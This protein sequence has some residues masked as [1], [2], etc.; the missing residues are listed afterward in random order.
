MTPSNEDPG[1]TQEM[2][3]TE[4]PPL[5]SAPPPAAQGPGKGPRRRVWLAVLLGVLGGLLLGAVVVWLVLAPRGTNPPAASTVATQTPTATAVATTPQNPPSAPVE[6]P[7]Q[8]SNNAPAPPDTSPPP[9]PDPTNPAPAYWVSYPDNPNVELRWSKVHD[10]SGVSYTLQIE[11]WMGGGAGWGDPKVYSDLHQT[12]YDW[13]VM[14]D[15]KER[16]RVIAVDGAGNKSDPSVWWQ[17]IPTD[18]S[19]AASQNAKP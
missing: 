8:Q 7:G 11:E 15:L 10:P 5:G 6:Q 14:S 3:V 4:Q 18:A 9:T 1:V 17:L 13:K 12:W 19:T 16:W 2:P